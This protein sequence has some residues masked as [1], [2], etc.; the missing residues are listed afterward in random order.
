MPVVLDFWASWCEPCKQLSPV[1]EKLAAADNGTWL[2]AKVDVDANQRIAQSFGI[3]SIPTVM[4]V[5]G[6][7]LAEGF[8]GAL[9]EAQVRQFVD[10]LL[11]AASKMGLP[12]PPTDG[13]Q[14]AEQAPAGPPELDE[15]EQ[16]LARRDLAS[17]GAAF[18]R[19]LDREPANP[20]A[21][22]GQARV[23]LLER[24]GSVDVRQAAAA[25]DADPADVDA[26]L[27]AADAEVA[28]G[29]ID[30]G[31]GRLLGLVRRAAGE[32]RDRA[33]DHLLGLFSVLPPDDEQVGRARRALSSAL[34]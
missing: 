5:I 24:V 9:P 1:L 17:A 31:F 11:E 10:A 20:A 26:V 22:A 16:A 12:G 33:R 3:Q 27:T 2:L 4:A 8:R 32:E 30:E 13:P 28:E 34:F 6:G 25:A 18:Q 29:R 19:L 14:P 23:A 15:A 21:L 7:Q